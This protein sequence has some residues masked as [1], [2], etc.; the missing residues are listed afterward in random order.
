MQAGATHIHT[1]VVSVSAEWRA[2][3]LRCFEIGLNSQAHRTRNRRTY[4]SF[5][6]ATETGMAAATDAAAERPRPPPRA[7][8]LDINHELNKRIE[9]HSK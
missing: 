3:P 6:I 2:W 7:P 1:A 5:P 8:R 4:I 9:G